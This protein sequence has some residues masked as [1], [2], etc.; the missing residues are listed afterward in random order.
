M[1]ICK[2]FFNFNFIKY[3]REEYM[4]AK[5]A[6]EEAEILKKKAIQREKVK[7]DYC[8]FRTK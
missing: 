5:K 6:A 3:K 7:H 4:K 2:I 8:R 1:Y